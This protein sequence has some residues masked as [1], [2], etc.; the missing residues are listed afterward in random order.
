MTKRIE[1]AKKE[2]LILTREV[3]SLERKIAKGD[4]YWLPQIELAKTYIARWQD[5]LKEAEAA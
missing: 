4:G 5:E 2:I 1:T 3:K